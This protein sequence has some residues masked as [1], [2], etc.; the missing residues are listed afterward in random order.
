MCRYINVN[1][2]PDLICIPDDTLRQEEIENLD[3]VAMHHMPNDMPLGLAPLQT[4]GDGNCFPRTISYLLFKIQA[5]YTEIQVCLVY[6]AVRN[7]AH[8]LDENYVSLGEHNFYDHDTLPEQYAQ[9]PDNY[10]PHVTFNMTQ[11]YK[12]EAIE[13]LMMAH[14]WGYGKYSRQQIL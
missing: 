12:R 11:L 1:E 8:Y 10:N 7:M 3:L 4:A 13:L 2:I 9:Y 6:E 5:R 14:T